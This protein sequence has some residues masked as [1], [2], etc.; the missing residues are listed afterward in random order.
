M[1]NQA[2]QIDQLN[3]SSAFLINLVE[4]LAKDKCRIICEVLVENQLA[5][6]K[7]KRLDKKTSIDSIHDSIKASNRAIANLNRCIR[8]EDQYGDKKN[9]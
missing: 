6:S 2:K 9:E 8:K 7:L 5:I 3:R 1:N 4:S